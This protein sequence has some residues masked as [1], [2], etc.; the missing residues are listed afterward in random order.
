MT[1]TL[2]S[3]ARLLRDHGLLREIIRGGTWTLDPDDV[4]GSD[5]PFLDVTYDTRRIVPGSLLFCKGAF[6]PEYLDGADGRGLA[7]WC[8]GTDLSSHSSAPGLVVEDVRAAMSLLSAE[9]F[10]RPQDELTVMGITGTKGKTTTAYFVHAILDAY[11]GGRCAMFSSVDDF[12]DG[13]TPVESNLTTPESLDAFRMMRQARDHGMTHLVMEVSS[14]AYKVERVYGLTFDVGAFLNIS[15]DHVS[16]IEHPTFED[17]LACKRRI[18]RNSR[19]L[20]L[21]ADCAHR[22][23]L[24]QDAQSAHVPVT[25]FAL[26]GPDGAGTPADVTATPVDGAPDRY[27]FADSHGPVCETALRME[28]AFNAANAAAAIAICELAGV[29]RDSDAF[30]AI[31]TVRV[32][33]RMERF[34]DGDVVAYVDYAHNFVSVSTLMDYVER[35]YGARHP[36][37]ILVTGSTGD[38]AV[39][40][41]EGIIRAAQ[42]RAD[43]IILTQEDT[44]TEPMASICEEMKGY[45]T[46]PSTECDIILDRTKAVEEAIRDARACGRPAVVL[47]IGKGE[48]RWIKEHGRHVPYEGDG[49]IVRRL[50]GCRTS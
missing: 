45:V 48:E 40:R 44:D 36:R 20:V 10:G 46:D 7:A 5:R 11:T 8:A 23:L 14:Q 37:V 29:P 42:G 35:R 2:A 47:V 21:G 24:E 3:A 6:R 43:R 49:P 32:S 15:P 4:E 26:E 38:K 27:A 12:L 50:L 25:T 30:D 39:D 34:A 17:Y 22:T 18:V 9:F 33:G 19:A 28:G 13:H 31:G 1:V 41:R 16:P